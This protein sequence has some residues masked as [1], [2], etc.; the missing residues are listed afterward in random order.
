MSGNIFNPN[1]AGVGNH[2]ITYSI[3]NGVCTD[4]QSVNIV[5]DTYVSVDIVSE[6]SVCSND[7]AFILEANP[8]SGT[9]SGVGVSG[10]Y[11]DPNISGVGTFPVNYIYENGACVSNN[12]VNITVNPSPIA[13]ISNSQTTFCENSPSFVIVASP[14]VGV[15]SGTGVS[16]VMFNPAEAGVGNHEIQ[17]N[18]TNNFGCS[19]SANAIFTVNIVPDINF[20]LSETQICYNAENLNLNA[21]PSGGS[22][23]GDGIIGNQFSPSIAGPGEHN[24][25]YTYS[26]SEACSAYSEQIITVSE[27]IIINL[28][29]TNTTCY[30]KNNGSI[31][32]EISGGQ[33]ELN[34]NWS[35]G[36]NNTN[37]LE[38]L[39]AGIYKITVTDSWNC[40]ESNNITIT[41][42]EQLNIDFSIV[43]N[44]LC[45]NDSNGNITINVTGGTNPYYYNWNDLNN[46]TSPSIH[47]LPSG[48]YEVIITDYN[49][50]TGT[51]S[52]NLI[53]PEPLNAYI[54][55]FSDVNCGNEN[56]GTASVSA[57]GGTSPYSYIWSDANNST[58]PSITGLAAGIYVVSV[59]DANNCST[60]ASVTISNP[61][62]L[63]IIVNSQN[64]ICS[65]NLGSA[66]VII[67]TGQEPFSYQW[68]TGQNTGY[69][70]N[71]QAG[72]Y[73]I[74]VTDDNN[75][76]STEQVIISIEGSINAGIIQNIENICFG[77]SNA[78][79]FAQSINAIEPL[80]YHWSNGV[81]TALNNNLPAGIYEVFLT[82]AWGCTGSATK[83]VKEG[84]K[85]NITPTITAFGCHGDSNGSISIQISGGQSPYDILWSNGSTSNYITD[86]A[87]GSYSVT[88]NDANS[89]LTIESY[90]VVNPSAPLYLNI[91]KKDISCYGY[92]DGEI[93]INAIGGMPEY[94]YLWE[95]NN[96]S[97]TGSSASNLA[98]GT[99][100]ITVLDSQNCDFDTL[101]VIAEPKHIEYSFISVNPSCIGNDDGYVEVSVIGGYPPY[102]ISWNNQT[103]SA[104]IITGLSQGVYTFTLTDNAGCSLE[105]NTVFLIDDNAECLKIPNAFSP[106]G[107]GINETWIIENIENYPWAVIQVFNRWGQ[108]MFEGKGNAAPWDGTWNGKIV[109]TGGY[110]YTVDL[111]NGT[112][113]C[114]IVSV[115]Q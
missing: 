113:Y 1:I 107:D 76:K 70:S 44:P 45:H 42:P 92:S 54:S 47:N 96:N 8:S 46:S 90:S 99:Y 71:L 80:N 20:S 89:C 88:I 109:P 106:N 75:C 94:T 79:L 7:L 98:K 91:L 21:S 26:N 53:N 48:N 18:I 38:N 95:Y 29:G 63:S 67:Q 87:A 104:E 83:E 66:Q 15:F 9:W 110:I 23:S 111:L 27:P 72:T 100:Y 60:S 30:S 32:A 35:T 59:N 39:F 41:Q 77:D 51:A 84:E 78:E 12:I 31:A 37:N 22:F 65:H 49:S 57:T 64:I 25:I 24:I 61:G 33:G 58:S 5:V 97:F 85:I 6:L 28:L 81:N 16:G 114:G 50:C 52:I 86:L 55:S 19:D 40:S 73:T 3:S 102:N 43:E 112:R 108:L 13:I 14:P 17:Y 69:I 82:D 74:T 68:S 103:A 36:A 115:I 62:E 10:N 11:F 101:V 93:Q 56:S 2:T 4:I 34:I 105:T